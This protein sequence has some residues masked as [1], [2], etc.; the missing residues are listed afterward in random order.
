MPDVRR[1]RPARKKSREVAYSRRGWSCSF[2]ANAVRRSPITVRL[3]TDSVN[4]FRQQIYKSLVSVAPKPQTAKPSARALGQNCS[5]IRRASSSE[6]KEGANN[7]P[8]SY[9]QH[10]FP[11][12]GRAGVQSCAKCGRKRSRRPLPQFASGKF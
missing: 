7:R 9:T 4:P 3:G 11:G 1:G 10:L 12:G 5:A 6:I 2:D 8:T